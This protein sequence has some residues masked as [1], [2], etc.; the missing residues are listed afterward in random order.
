MTNFSK[1]LFRIL[2]NSFIVSM[3]CLLVSVVSTEGT[4]IKNVFGFVGFYGSLLT[5]NL[6]VLSLIFVLLASVF[7]ER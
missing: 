5:I 6:F 2:T 3:I 7:R 4:I 1:L